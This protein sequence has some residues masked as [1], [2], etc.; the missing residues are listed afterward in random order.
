MN[1]LLYVCPPAGHCCIV[2]P[3]PILTASPYMQHA[4]CTHAKLHAPPQVK[5]HPAII[6]YQGEADAKHAA[7]FA[8]WD[9]WKV[10]VRECWII[11]IVYNLM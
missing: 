5:T 2:I 8:L 10:R 6:G 9:W 1:T 4:T 3:T 11:Y 7:F